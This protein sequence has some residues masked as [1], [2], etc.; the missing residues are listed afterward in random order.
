MDNLY[1]KRMHWLWA[2]PTYDNGSNGTSKRNTYRNCK[3]RRII[4]GQE[5]PIDVRYCFPRYLYDM[6]T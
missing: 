2:A 3:K 4:R 5:Q 6:N 1:K